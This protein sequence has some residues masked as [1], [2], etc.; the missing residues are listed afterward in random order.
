MKFS[1]STVAAA[2]L[3]T[4]LIA[5]AV[6]DASA[7]AG[8]PP[9]PASEAG[10]FCSNQ[11]HSKCTPT[12]N[13]S[14]PVKGFDCFYTCLIDCQEKVIDS[15]FQN[16]LNKF[17]SQV[18]AAS[19]SIMAQMSS[20][21]NGNPSISSKPTT[22]VAPVITPTTTPAK[23]KPTATAAGKPTVTGSAPA[24]TSTDDDSAKMDAS[25]KFCRVQCYTQCQSV[26]NKSGPLKAYACYD[27]C[28]QPCLSKLVTSGA[29]HTEQD[30]DKLVLDA[31]SNIVNND[32][33][34][35]D[36]DNN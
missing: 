34:G 23:P 21:I 5:T 18:D 30:A 13:K 3:A 29:N 11:C 16:D 20:I 36:N 1:S 26:F 8:P 4:L 24:P 6:P 35:N 12:W 31:L 14:G 33:D 25:A 32:N 10:D 19:T 28:L 2:A 22:T 9:L 17:S 7:A 15:N 27:D